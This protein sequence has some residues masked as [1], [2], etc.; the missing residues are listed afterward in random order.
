MSRAAASLLL[1]PSLLRPVPSSRR[2]GDTTTPPYEL[3]ARV[4]DT[5]YAWKDYRTEARRIHEL[6]RRWGP[7]RARTLLDVACGTGTHLRYLARWFEVTGLDRSQPM[8]RQAR[9]KLPKVRFVRGPMQ[10]FRLAERFDVI[11]CLFSAI[12]YV[13]S[14]AELRSTLS[15]LARHLT[16]GGL[17]LVE[18]WVTPDAYE[19][20]SFHLGT[21]GSPRLPIARLN[22]STRRGSRSVMDMHYLVADGA[23]V[24]H[25][26]ERH[27]MGLFDPRTMLDAFRRAGLSARRVRSPFRPDRGL[28]LG[29]RPRG[30]ARRTEA[31]TRGNRRR[32][33]ST[34]R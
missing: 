14:E 13:R 5:V 20:G 21:Y 3:A 25:W 24:H 9:R 2:T 27:D 32:L 18:P 29:I 8:L 19:V 16:P 31:R 28:Y 11:T 23:Q 30:R 15:N 1:S 34:T 12:G 17:V 10:R 7:P 6:V 33:S 26:V 22:N 4:Y